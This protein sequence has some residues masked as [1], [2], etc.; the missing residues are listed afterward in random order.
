M[1]SR[2]PTVIQPLLAD[3]LAQIDEQLPDFVVGFYIHGSIALDAFNPLSSDIDTL[4]VLNRPASEG[5]LETLT[6][7]HQ[8]TAGIYPKWLLEVSY[9]QPADLGRIQPPA[10][11]PYP[12]YHD[13]KLELSTDFDQNAVTWWLLKHRGITLKGT[14]AGELPFDVETSTLIG[15]MKHNLN[16]YWATYTREP[17]RMAWLLSDFGIQWAVLGVLRQYYTFR[18][19]DITSKTGAG[20]YALTQLPARWHKLIREAMSI[21]EESG[22]SSYKSKVGRALDALQFMRYIIQLC[23]TLA[24]EPKD[25]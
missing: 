8:T 24:D 20:A 6:R 9:L 2:I 21:R 25:S 15:W 3:F 14:S 19:H 5:D 22:S 23:N 4:A 10:S 1:H 17:S 12:L 11:A 16:L 18:E 7:I 13:N